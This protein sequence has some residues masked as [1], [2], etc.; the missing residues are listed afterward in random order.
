VP[1]A[2]KQLRV[3]FWMHL[4]PDAEVRVQLHPQIYGVDLLAMRWLG[5]DAV[6]ASCVCAASAA[7]EIGDEVVDRSRVTDE[8]SHCRS[9]R[10]PQTSPFDGAPLAR[11]VQS[12]ERVCLAPTEQIRDAGHCLR[13]IFEPEASVEIVD[14]NTADAV[15]KSAEAA[16]IVLGCEPQ[17]QGPQIRDSVCQRERLDSRRR[18]IAAEEEDRA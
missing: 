8:D 11:E 16:R 7:P 9:A 14:R 17:T 18:I 15:H 2:L 3:H 13:E 6:A 10:S 12:L 5:L 4:A 1:L